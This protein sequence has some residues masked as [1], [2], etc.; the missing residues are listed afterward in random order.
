MIFRMALLMLLVLMAT[1][2]TDTSINEQQT[3]IVHMD[4]AKIASKDNS[5]K[6]YE[7]VM[8]TITDLSA[9]K[10]DSTSSPQLL[11]TYETTTGFAAKLSRKQLE[12]LRQL[13]GFLSATPDEMLKLHTTHSP[14]FLGL[15]SGKGLWN[16]QNL[17]SDV[18]IGV[19]DSGI[20][21]EH[22]SF[23]DSSMSSV[24]SRWKGIC[25]EG[26]NFTAS[27]CNR[28]LIGARAFYK[29]Y[30]AKGGVINGTEEYKSARDA[31]GHGTHTSS[32]AAGGLIEDANFLGL[33]K[34]SASGM[35]YTSRI[36][37]YKV[38]WFGGCASSD[39]LAGVDQAILD[40][41]DVLS[42]SI[43]GSDTPY[44]KDNIAIVIG[45]IIDPSA[46]AQKEDSAS[47]PQLLYVYEKITGFAAKL[48]K[49]QLESLR[50]LNG[51]LSATPDELLKLHTTHSPQFLGLER[52]KGLWNSKNL[53]S[54]V[55]VGVVD[56]GIWPEHD[57][58]K[59]STMSPVPSRWKG[60]CEEGT[61][62]TASNC[63]RRLIGARAY[64]KGYEAAGRRIHE[65][66]DYKSARDAQGHG[67]HVSSTA[68]GSLV[69]NASFLGLAKGSASGI[70][71]TSRIAA[72]K[73]CWHRGCAGSDIL[74]AMDQAI[75][76]GVDVLSLSLGTGNS[77]PYV[78]TVSNTAPWITTVAASYL[79]RSFLAT[80]KLGN[81]QTLMGSSMFTGKSTVQLPIVYG[82][83][84]GTQDAVYCDYGS[85]KRTL[86]KGKIVLCESGYVSRGEMA[87]NVKLAGGAGMIVLNIDDDGEEQI[88]YAYLLPAITVGATAG[89]AIKKYISSNKKATASITFNGTVYGN[90]APAMAAFS[91][92]G[93]S[94]IGPQVIKPDITAPGV[95]I[96]AAWPPL[97]SPTSADEDKRSV[98]FNIVSG[99]SMS[100]P[101]VSGIAAL[102]KSVRTNWSPAAIKSAL[103]TTAYTLDNTKNPIVDVATSSS[104]T[105]FA[106]GS[107]H[108]N[109]E[110]AS[111]PGLIYN[112]TE[113]DY[114][115]HLCSLGYTS[116]QITLFSGSG[117]NFSCP[118][119]RIPLGDLNYPSFAVNFTG[120]V[121]N[122]AMTFKRTVTNVGVPGSSYTV[123]VQEPKDASV[124]VKPTVL[125]FKKLGEEL[126]YTVS[127]V[128]NRGKT[129]GGSSYSFG[130]L[131]WVSGKY[132]VGSPIAVSWS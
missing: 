119:T 28:K 107:G 82:K 29:G 27:N 20:W 111:D 105:P 70:R 7:A 35:R 86:V 16:S 59:D 129:S 14:Q 50:Q 116:A 52:G 67:T 44:Y 18:I 25:E 132:T 114:L 93:P 63:N 85:L 9:Q 109:P 23:K 51:F 74:A 56:S 120:K 4:K 131:V 124:T 130:A 98:P 54:D 68:A 101:H 103:M 22:D 21:P 79:D 71:Y 87:D 45:S 97:N 30:E 39:I 128:G 78:S 8:D 49:K 69:K 42:L 33:A 13:N 108:V 53:E 47:S 5:R 126:S 125:N 99:T 75:L 31:I 1:T 41:V 76:D 81:K 77:G 122:K 6:W 88:A 55:I 123:K 37:A 48:S 96:L 83:S 40:G 60:I 38:C 100:C 84:A 112:I 127:V 89:K 72:Y 106:F 117:S 43:G 102:I 92:R 19:V 66:E 115:N 80:V 110:I 94:E 34:G 62:F 36:A 17:E 118:R 57:S 90:R 32:T 11:Y 95:N 61:N 3:Y 10:E 26:S 2:S 12:S 58:F 46:S 15:E 73:V 64:Y 104:A 24:P 91:S 121:Q 65:T 113:V